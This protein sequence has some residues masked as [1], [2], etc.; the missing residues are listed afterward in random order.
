LQQGKKLRLF[1]VIPSIFSVFIIGLS[2]NL[3]CPDAHGSQTL[4]RL[5]YAPKYAAWLADVVREFVGQRVL[6]I[7]AGVG[8]LT[9]YLSPRELYWAAD[10]NPL[11]VRNLQRMTASEPYLRASL[12]EIGRAETFPESE[13]FDTV[14]CRYSLECAKDDA[15]SLRNV[16][17]M[18]K[19]GGVAIVVVPQGPNLF[20]SLDP[21][22]RHLRRYSEAQLIDLGA[23]AGFQAR[24]I[25]PINRIST[26][27]W[28]WKGRI[29]KKSNVEIGSVQ[30]FNFLVPIIRRI[31]AGLPFP[32]LSLVG[33]FEKSGPG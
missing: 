28:W 33:I 21:P 32:P 24:K 30:F 2:R 15:L 6:E 17:R 1:D 20:G 25:L 11:Y 14:I 12:I 19:P 8:V 27:L 10:S 7:G 13:E 26:P 18:L 22:S 16:H 3:Y 29:R 31:D 9:A 4:S 5:H 23:R